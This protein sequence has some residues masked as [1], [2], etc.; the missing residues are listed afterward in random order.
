MNLLR[1]MEAGTDPGYVRSALLCHFDAVTVLEITAGGWPF[2]HV[3]V[4]ERDHQTRLAV[5]FGWSHVGWRFAAHSPKHIL[6]RLSLCEG[7]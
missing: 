7:Q 6:P 3:M 4:C 2:Q 5:L 1:L